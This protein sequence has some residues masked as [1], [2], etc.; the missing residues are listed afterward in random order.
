MR[1]IGPPWALKAGFGLLCFLGLLAGGFFYAGQLLV[2]ERAPVH[3]DV[4]IVLAGSFSRAL[5]AADLYHEGFIPRIWVTRPE[6]ERELKQLDGLGVTYP[7]QEEI[8]R[9]VLLK[10]GVPSERVE[11]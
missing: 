2:H 3:A 10:K 9:A 1:A 4:G 8:S 7:R 6:R 5:Y 11:V